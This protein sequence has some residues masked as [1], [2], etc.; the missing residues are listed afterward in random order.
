[1]RAAKRLTPRQR[2]LALQRARASG[3]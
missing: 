1:M 3:Y 2:R